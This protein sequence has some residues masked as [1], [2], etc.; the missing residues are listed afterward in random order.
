MGYSNLEIEFFLYMYPI[1]L[2]KHDEIDEIITYSKVTESR[3]EELSIQ[4]C[5]Y[6]YINNLVKSWL[7]DLSNE[8][9]KFIELR[10]FKNLG[11]KKIASCLYYQN[12]SGVIKLNRKIIE[13]IR[14]KD[15]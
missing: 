13:K 3:V 1:A 7:I 14:K 15:V 6:T 5:F 11:Y 12:H 4:D 2:S 9:Q 8:E 10:Y